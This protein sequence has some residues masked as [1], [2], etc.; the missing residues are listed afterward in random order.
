MRQQIREGVRV[1]ICTSRVMSD[2]DFAFLKIHGIKADAILHRSPSDRRGDGEYK[3]AKLTAY[4]SQRELEGAL[5]FD[6]AK[7]V[8]AS[9]RPL[10]VFVL[11]P[12]PINARLAR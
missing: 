10:G 11:N 4:F 1:T 3:I 2:A 5:M 12:D 8:R 6:D 9:V 7:E